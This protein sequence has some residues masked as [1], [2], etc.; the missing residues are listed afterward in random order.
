MWIGARALC[1]LLFQPSQSAAAERAQAG[2]SKGA[3]QPS[4][5]TSQWDNAGWRIS[6]RPSHPSHPQ[7]YS[8][9]AGGKELSPLLLELPD[10]EKGGNCV[11][12]LTLC[13][14][15]CACVCGGRGVP[16][17]LCPSLQS[18]VGVSALSLF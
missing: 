8:A 9:T 5:P 18:G 14:C 17:T 15:A 11:V 1:L 2:I 16:Q 3:G 10:W 13:A 4:P 6:Y 12:F 7:L